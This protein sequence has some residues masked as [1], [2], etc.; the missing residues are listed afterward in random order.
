MVLLEV[1]KG[2]CSPGCCCS[3]NGWWRAFGVVDLLGKAGGTACFIDGMGCD[4]RCNGV[5]VR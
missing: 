3:L 5:E 4:I 2:K 1:T